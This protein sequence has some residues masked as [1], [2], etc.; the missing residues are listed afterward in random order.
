MGFVLFKTETT[1]E[2]K[3]THK[4]H[5]GGSHAQIIYFWNK[6]YTPGIT[7][8]IRLQWISWWQP[9]LFLAD[10]T[11]VF[12]RSLAP[13]LHAKGAPVAAAVH[14]WSDP[15]NI[16]IYKLYGAAYK[17]NAAEEE[18]CHGSTYCAAFSGGSTLSKTPS[19]TQK[20]GSSHLN[21]TCESV[22][23]GRIIGALVANMREL[24][25]VYHIIVPRRSFSKRQYHNMQHRGGRPSRRLLFQRWR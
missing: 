7:Q 1:N 16:K 25:C 15:G 19:I 14:R 3:T 24:R 18:V 20:I 9:R 8:T 2:K 12:R 23:A 13:A 22:V 6:L 21:T 5:K 4:T 11:P 17:K 10:Q